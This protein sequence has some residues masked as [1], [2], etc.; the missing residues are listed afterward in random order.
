MAPDRLSWSS[1]PE[2]SSWSCCAPA[3][4]G[5]VA[6]A[7]RLPVR[8]HPRLHRHRARHQQRVIS[9]VAGWISTLG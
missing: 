9:S 7:R 8:L 3:T 2:S 1:S 6:R 5:C 4:C